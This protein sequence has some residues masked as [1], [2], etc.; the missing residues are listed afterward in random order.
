MGGTVGRTLTLTLAVGGIVDTADS[1]TI[2]GAVATSVT[3]SARRWI[4]AHLWR[5][6]RFLASFGLPS[7]LTN[8]LAASIQ[9]VIGARPDVFSH[10]I[11]TVRRLHARMRGAK[12]SY[13]KALW[14][15]RRAKEIADYPV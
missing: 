2:G 10:N 5:H 7:I 8:V 4:V 1:N 15:L 14:L 9:I 6:K 3:S 11:E 13:D 12:A